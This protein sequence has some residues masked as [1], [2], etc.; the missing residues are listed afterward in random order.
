MA[1]TILTFNGIDG[2][3]GGYLL[4]PMP[5]EMIGQVVRGEPIDPKD[6]HFKELQTRHEGKQPHFGAVEG[7][8]VKDLSQAGWGV[9]FAFGAGPA[10]R[11]ALSPLLDH[12][13]RQ[14][15]QQKE[16]YYKEYIGVKG[17]RPSET[18][19]QFLTRQG[20]GPGP[21]D[22]DKVPYYLLIVGDPQSI[23]Y[24]FQYQLDVQYGVGRIHFDTL[25]EYDQYARSVVEAET[26]G[27][28]LPR[29]A[30]FFAVRNPED[31]KST[32]LNSSH[33]GI[34]YAVF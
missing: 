12:R 1:E 13:K 21:A 20:A 9:I 19:Q 30:T 22:P 28:A 34:S 16:H 15:T 24:S 29:K 26:S 4:S 8:D 17:Y 32:R 14:A 10:I 6:P 25:E 23:P 5:A 18:K 11:E 7:V 33:L 3:N 27:L 31:R 2:D